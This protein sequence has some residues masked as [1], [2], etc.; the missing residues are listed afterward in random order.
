[1]I[2]AVA[3]VAFAGGYFIGSKSGGPATGD[4]AEVAEAGAAARGSATGDSD[5]I[6]IGDSPVL[7][8]A[9]APITIIEFSEFQCPYC[10]RGSKTM[11][12]ILEKYPNDV[13]V[14]FKHFPLAFHKQAA[15]A[16]K[17]ALAAG[18]QGKFWE[19]HD[20]L[21]ENQK[22]L[23]GKSPAD[24]KEFGAGLAKQIGID[25]NKFKKDFDN[26]KWDEIIKR[27]QALGKKLSVRGTPHFF[28]NGERVK[29]AQPAAKFEEIIKKQ[30]EEAKK[31]QQAGVKRD[32]LYAKMVEKNFADAPKPEARKP[33]AA[34][35]QMVPVESNDPVK[36]NTKDPLVT[37]VE[38]SDFQ[39][40][41]CSRVNP[42]IDKIME[43]YGDHVRVVFKQNPL[44][45]HKQAPAASEAALAANEQGKFWEMHDLLF[46]NQK[47]F[48]TQD[49]TELTTKLA[50]QLGLNTAKFKKAL[51][52]GKYKAKIKADQQ[53]AG[54]VGARGTPNFFV[55]GVQVV[56]AKPYS[57]FDDVIKK[58]IDIAKKIKKDKGLSGDKL[59]AAVVAH[60]KKN[61]P[62]PSAQKPKK[63]K[64]PAK[65]DTDKLNV[66]KSYT[67]GPKDAPV[68]IYEF[69]DFQCPYCSRANKS[70]NKVMDEYKGKVRVVFKAFPLPFHKQ[71]EPAHR[72]A[73]AAGKQGK[74]WQ[75]HDKLFA[76]QG[77]LKQDGVFEKYA[78]EL[79]LNMA[80]FKKDFASNELKKQVQ[81][82]MAEGRKVGV[83]G[84]PAFFINGNRIVGAQPF[85][86]FAQVIDSELKN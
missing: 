2:I 34:K 31:M 8:K 1:M 43:N 12:E 35:V 23:K 79:G 53:L 45:F 42:T 54:K 25:V 22:Q 9:T 82:E 72:A 68:T 78:E 73:L 66:G 81:Q 56:G 48:K 15:D 11:K 37:I 33:Q 80:K 69:S 3:V 65:V 85:S 63:D 67:K 26:D 16:S 47:Q 40:P 57:A 49:M 55:N 52:S 27:D 4:Q 46:E 13:K 64:P 59:Y 86:K 5:T 36:G 71:A 74:F 7:G 24:M 17:V 6:P 51:E 39:C 19:M 44:P 21:F 28:V 60:N 76:D 38:F 62:K 61:A 41:F 29:G 10:A 77:A 32:Q 14:V 70:L 30:L 20:K 58:Q 83:R 84:T 18:E 75:M 50:Q